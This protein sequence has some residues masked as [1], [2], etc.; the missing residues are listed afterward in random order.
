MQRILIISLLFAIVLSSCNFL[1]SRRG[2]ERIARVHDKY[3]HRSDIQGLITPGVN[4]ADSAVITKRYIDNWVRQQ[5]YLSEAEE[6]LTQEET[7]F[8]RK[9]E[10]YKNSLLI[11]TYENQL[12]TQNMDTIISD[13]LM[14]QYYEKHQEDFKLRDNIVKLNFVKLPIDAPDM[15]L[16]RK[17]I[18]SEDRDDIAELEEYCINHAAAYFLDPDSW[19]VFSDILREI[20]LNPSNH[21]SYLRNTK[22]VEINDQ[23]YRYFLYLLDFKLEGSTSPLTYQADN[24]KAIILNHR[25]QELV[26]D[27]RQNL[28]LDAVKNSAFEIY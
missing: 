12:I 10:D 15:N 2:D 19:Y 13:E 18:R 11:F 5:L 8:Q 27:F 25:K 20:P 21:A 22:N 4:A 28:Y 26:N 16:V 3:L 23:Y 9:I 1:D 14:E 6:N 17:L 7:D 24:I